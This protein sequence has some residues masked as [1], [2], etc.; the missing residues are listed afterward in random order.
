VLREKELK[1]EYNNKLHLNNN[2]LLKSVQLQYN[3]NKIID[4][5]E[6]KLSSIKLKK[7]EQENNNLIS[8]IKKNNND[9]LQI[10]NDM[11]KK[12]DERRNMN[13]SKTIFF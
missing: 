4:D 9:L 10:N 7:I 2:E 6:I 11:D 13:K 8:I 1:E 5:N 3:E 12:N